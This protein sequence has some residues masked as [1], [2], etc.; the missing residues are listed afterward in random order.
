MRVP[1]AK[2]LSVAVNSRAVRVAVAMASLGTALG[3][4]A[5][6]KKPAIPWQTVAL[7]RPIAPQK[8]SLAEEVADVPDLNFEIA[9]PPALLPSP[10]T[11]PVRPHIPALPS[12]HDAPPE[13]MDTPQIVPQ[14]TPGQS[15]ALRQETEQNLRVAERNVTAAS[16]RRLN[17]TQSDLASKVKGF[18]SDARDAGR[19]GDWPRARDLAKKA[20]VLSEELA[21]SL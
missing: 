15:S 7:V 11:G 2:P 4:C 18:I 8:A 10:R 9:E 3:G 13:P 14:L 19:A 5:V 1:P 21:N 6:Q 12:N 17:P 16:R 20:Q